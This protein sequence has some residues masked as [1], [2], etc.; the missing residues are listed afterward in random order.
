VLWTLRNCRIALHFVACS[1]YV[2]P[3][4]IK[5]KSNQV[6]SGGRKICFQKCVRSFWTIVPDSRRFVF[7]TCINCSL[8][9]LLRIHVWKHILSHCIENFQY[10]NTWGT[11]Q[12]S[13][14]P[15]WVQII[16][17]WKKINVENQCSFWLKMNMRSEWQDL[18]VEISSKLFICPWKRHQN[19]IKEKL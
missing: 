3:P 18:R 5:L 16:H 6:L 15:F 4:G 17:D 8:F 9:A 11:F 13:F 14:T 7:I 10:V 12:V 2:G 19:P 1:I